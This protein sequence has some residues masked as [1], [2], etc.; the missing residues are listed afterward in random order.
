MNINLHKFL[1]SNI[2]SH[3]PPLA[4]TLGESLESH[5]ITDL[6]QLLTGQTFTGQI[7]SVHHKD[8]QI[9]IGNNLVLN[10]K[11]MGISDFNIG[12]NITFEIKEKTSAQILIKAIGKQEVP[13]GIIAKALHNA[14]LQQNERNAALVRALVSQNM[15]VDKQTILRTLK[16]VSEYPDAGLKE[17]VFLQKN[18]LEVNR[19]HIDQLE[20]YMGGRH[21]LAA[22]ID[23]VMEQLHQ[24]IQSLTENGEIPK[25]VFLVRDVL[26]VF[27][28]EQVF[29]NDVENDGNFLSP[30]QKEELIRL[31]G[32]LAKPRQYQEVT[33]NP[34]TE[35]NGEE[36]INQV[37]GAVNQAMAQS[38]ES[39]GMLNKM[40]GQI[41]ER[42]HE[43]GT[44]NQEGIKNLFKSE[45]FKEL[46][47]GQIR[48]QILIDPGKLADETDKAEY[49]KNIYKK[50]AE[51][52]DRLEK[53]FGQSDKDSAGVM[54]SCQNIKGNLNFMQSVNHLLPYLQLPL[55]LQDF[56]GHGD[57]YVYNRDTPKKKEG[58]FFTAFLHLD[59]EHLGATDAKISMKGKNVKTVFTLQDKDSMD[60]VEKNLPL[61]K[62]RLEKRGY[63]VEYSVTPVREE[64]TGNIIMEKL[65]VSCEPETDVKRY[66]FDVRM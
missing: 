18:G 23:E 49:I 60:L 54:G 50:I 31:L 65:R 4:E 57:L 1:N 30:L 43:Q 55:K 16:A 39:P 64:E 2:S 52:V 28:P 5:P 32:D 59:L 37:K 62:E 21:Q 7:L 20:R 27:H 56:N 3:N 19:I 14:G 29:S 12:D 58:E 6:K 10:A 44:L 13:E 48:S 35:E 25:A 34:V 41:I 61:L 45:V 24:K 22:Q 26:E 33:L 11:L 8:I 17:I 38:K 42:L 15:P 53:L 66:T 40:I 51:S 9:G 47:K 36:I 63:H 46:F